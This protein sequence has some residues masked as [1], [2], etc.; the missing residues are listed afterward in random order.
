MQHMGSGQFGSGTFGGE[1]LTNDINLREYKMRTKT[2]MYIAW[3]RPPGAQGYLI[4][5]NGLVASRTFDPAHTSTPISYIA[6]DVFTVQAVKLDT[7]KEG[8]IKA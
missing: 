3:D 2:L 8:S 6:G 4:L 1:T 5:K 7:I